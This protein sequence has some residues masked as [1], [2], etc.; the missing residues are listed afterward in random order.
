M[1][2]GYGRVSTAD[3]N[4]DHQA[5]ALKAA[6][7]ERMYFDKVTSRLPM[8]RRPQWAALAEQL[9]AGDV[10]TVT[11]MD[12]LGRSLLDL[13]GTLDGLRAAGVSVRSLSEEFGTGPA[14][15]AMMQI[16][17]VFAQ[18]ERG[19][20]SERTK[21]GQAAARARGRQGGRPCKIKDSQM[22]VFLALYADSNVTAGHIAELYGVSLSTVHS[23]ARTH[24]TPHTGPEKAVKK[25]GTIPQK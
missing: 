25:L 4:L 7:C 14:A 22:P 23:T 15:E 24:R 8:A 18:F 9:R 2:F 21:E 17:A 1:N 12:R 16:A 20:I 3:Q 11:R 19:L 5:D 13:L 6:G 10:V